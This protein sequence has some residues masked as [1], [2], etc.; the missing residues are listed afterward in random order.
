[1]KFAHLRLYSSSYCSR[2]ILELSY[3][4]F[5]M[6]KCLPNE[7][8][9][10]SLKSEDIT[11]SSSS[12]W[13]ENG[14]GE[15]GDES[16]LGLVW[17]NEATAAR[18]SKVSGLVSRTHEDRERVLSSGRGLSLF[19]ICPERGDRLYTS[20]QPNRISCKTDKK[21]RFNRSNQHSIPL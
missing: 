5:R 15:V 14:G 1:M 19:R 6:I 17:E 20:I 8:T 12:A 16:S 10:S 18:S 13:M 9:K 7:C 4:L 2:A 3:C 11:C 21:Y